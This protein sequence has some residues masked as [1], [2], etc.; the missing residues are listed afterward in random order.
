MADVAPV[1]EVKA[2]SVTVW[3]RHA[4]RTVHAKRNQTNG[5]GATALAESDSKTYDSF[6][7][8]YYQGRKRRQ[9]R[10]SKIEKARKLAKEVAQR[11]ASD[12][13]QAE[14]LTEFDRRIYVLA[15]AEATSLGLEV[16]TACHKLADL[17]K[18]LR[19]GTIEEAVTFFNDHGQQVRQGATSEEVYQQY[20]D[21]LEKRGAGE[22]YL[23][24]VE[25]IVGGFVSAFPGPIAR[26]ETPDIDDF[27]DR[28]GGKARNKNNWRRGIIGLFNFARKKN[29]LPKSLEHAAAA[30]SE[31]SDPRKK[32]TTEQE[33]AALL[34]RNDIYTPEEMRLILKA[35]GPA[36]RLALEIKAFSGVRTEEIAR[37]WW[38]MI[39]EKDNC[40]RVPDAV[41]K[42]NARLVPI[43][44]N[45]GKRLRDYAPD[46]KHGRVVADWSSANSLWHAWKGAVE[47]AGIP[48]RRNVFR[49]S[50]ISY[51]LAIL[52]D[53]GRV[54][55]E[56][57]TSPAMI[58]KNYLS[59][60]PISRAQA[61]EWFAL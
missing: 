17:Q 25:R 5:V 45:L 37:L 58:K 13:V 15:Q 43:L 2:G 27:L 38:V 48:Y 33:A 9:T 31:F 30:T 41:G 21:H 6:I 10:C 14:F 36:L 7:V 59:R 51:R 46:L 29:F 8:E 26:I 11:L 34:Q 20:L 44:P 32:I 19:K 1:E 52:E 16:D 42:L 57:G 49:N 28:L 47:G 50:Y 54:A 55:A 23:R 39:D 12:G 4:P 53:I 3:I 61:A 18:R 24:D 35:T 22:Y 60:A 56:T 40:I